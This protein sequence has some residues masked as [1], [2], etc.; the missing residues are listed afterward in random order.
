MEGRFNHGIDPKGRLTIPS[1]L[2]GDLGEVCHVV[3]GSGKYLNLYPDESWKRFCEKFIG[4]SQSK[5]GNMRILFA[6]SAACEVDAQGRIL[7]PQEL[8]DAVGISKNVTIVALPDRAELWDA[9]NYRQME[10]QYFSAASMED[11]Y[12]ELGL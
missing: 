8:R 12:Q 7:I 5:A 3:R 11:L 2:R 9:D 4:L 6:N 1:Q 10:E